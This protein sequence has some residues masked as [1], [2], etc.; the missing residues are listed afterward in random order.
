MRIR[1][2][3]NVM[4]FRSVAKRRLPAPV[5]HYL[6]G[7][8][9]DELSLARNT[10]AFGDYELLPSQLSDVSSV[11]LRSTLFGQEV[12]WPVMIAPTGASKLFHADGEQAVARAAE[13]FGMVYSL[14]TLSTATIEDVAAARLFSSISS[15]IAGSPTNGSIVAE[16]PATLRC[17]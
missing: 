14:S 15:R 7:G 13:K 2:C 11:D 10:D 6:D 12:D 3:N 1:H 9:D 5:F 4:D 8:A 17:S 16:M